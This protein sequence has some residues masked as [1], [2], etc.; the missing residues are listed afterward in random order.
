MKTTAD[1]PKCRFVLKTPDFYS[2]RAR[3]RPRGADACQKRGRERDRKQLGCSVGGYGGV[4][5]TNLL[6]EEG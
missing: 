1:P 6:L 2:G 5:G 4:S 3:H